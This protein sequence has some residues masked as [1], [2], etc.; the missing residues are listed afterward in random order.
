MKRTERYEGSHARDDGRSF[1]CIYWVRLTKHTTT[2]STRGLPLIAHSRLQTSFGMTTQCVVLSNNNIYS[3]D[4]NDL[5][6]ML[7]RKPA[8]TDF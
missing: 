2:R 6:R 5:V 4:N 3:D 8:R 1:W 7:T